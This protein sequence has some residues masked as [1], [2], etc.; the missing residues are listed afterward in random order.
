[1]FE[2]NSRTGSGVSRREE[3]EM[4]KKLLERAEA[5][6]APIGPLKNFRPARWKQSPMG[7][8]FAPAKV[9]KHTETGRRLSNGQARQILRLSKTLIKERED[10]SSKNQ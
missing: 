9:L 3:R 8:T 7:Q 6:N 4:S 2:I 10:G 1:V 5:C